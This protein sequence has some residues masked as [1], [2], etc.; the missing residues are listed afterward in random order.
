MDATLEI[1]ADGF[2]RVREGVE[3]VLEGAD[4]E[5]LRWRADAEANTIAWLVWHLTRVQDD[6]LAEAFDRTQVWHEEGWAERFA[7][8]FDTHETGYGQSSAEVGQVTT[9]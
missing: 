8:P 4:G 3:E 5:L 2:V 7:L 1:M 6:H 9:S